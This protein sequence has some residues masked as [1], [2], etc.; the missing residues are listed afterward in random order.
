MNIDR[1][2]GNMAVT[3]FGELISHFRLVREQKRIVDL[4]LDTQ[5]TLFYEHYDIQQHDQRPYPKIC[6]IDGFPWM[7]KTH[8]IAVFA[9]CLL[10][11]LPRASICV[12]SPGRRQAVLMMEKIREHVLFLSQFKPFIIVTGKN[13]NE[14]LTIDC[15]YH[16]STVMSLPA[17]AGLTR[18]ISMNVVIADD[19]SEFPVDFVN[20]TILPMMDYH[21]G[22]FSF[23]SATQG[24]DR[25]GNIN[26]YSKF[27]DLVNPDL[28]PMFPVLRIRK[29]CITCNSEDTSCGHANW[30]LKEPQN[31][32]IDDLITRMT[33][34]LGLN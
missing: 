17:K 15:D 4:L 20:N 5:M 28:T 1:E 24:D 27:L 23:L 19:A 9:A 3:E 6:A 25:E 11:S 8:V 30:E 13:N 22:S 32:Q 33:N 18:G 10:L 14:Q 29:G 31:A 7:G 12:F 34:A 26:W 16:M 2:V 21:G